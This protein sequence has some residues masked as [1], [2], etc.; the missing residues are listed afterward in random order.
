MLQVRI[1]NRLQWLICVNFEQI[2]QHGHSDPSDPPG[3]NTILI[4]TG[5]R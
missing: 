5:R 1:A 2:H 3:G 4:V